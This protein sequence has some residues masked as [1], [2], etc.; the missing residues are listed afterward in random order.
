M[1]WA[2]AII[3]LQEIDLEFQTINRRLTEIEATLKDQSELLNAQQEV[4][5]KVGAAAAAQKTQKRLA[6]H[7]TSTRF[8]TMLWRLRHGASAGAMT[9]ETASQ[10]LWVEKALQSP[11]RRALSCDCHAMDGGTNGV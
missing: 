9:G 3:R 5:N 6:R 11:A 1:S 10:I 8:G 7:T 2:E 4:E